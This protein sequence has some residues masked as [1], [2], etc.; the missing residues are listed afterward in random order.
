VYRDGGDTYSWWANLLWAR[1]QGATRFNM[2]GSRPLRS[3]GSFAYKRK[4][5]GRV[6]RR[7]RP[8]GHWLFQSRG[9]GPGLRRQINT[10]GVIAERGDAFLSVWLAGD[11]APD[12]RTLQRSAHEDGL[13]G[14]LVVGPG[15]S[16]T[17]AMPAANAMEA[18]H[19]ARR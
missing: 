17:V 8:Y 10:L 19:M 4:W 12:L 11:D 5:G 15:P 3:N 1:Q 13:D 9:M 2:G 7:Q 14:L 6:V 18:G 16:R